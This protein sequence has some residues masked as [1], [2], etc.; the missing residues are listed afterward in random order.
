MRWPE[1]LAMINSSRPPL[2]YAKLAVF[3][4]TQKRTPFSWPSRSG[5]KALPYRPSRELTILQRLLVL[6][7]FR[8][9]Q[10]R[11]PNAIEALTFA[12]R[13][14][15]PPEFHASRPLNDGEALICAFA[16][17]RDRPPLG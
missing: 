13:R 6:R 7:R 17:E 10:I 8:D 16:A 11:T 14:S 9:R 15:T 1:A 4:E 2:I 3:W 5:A 12:G